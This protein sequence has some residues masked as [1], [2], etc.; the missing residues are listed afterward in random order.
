[1]PTK[2]DKISI[3]PNPANEAIYIK[4]LN[5]S[6]S[7]TAEIYN[8]YGNKI[9]SIKNYNSNQPINIAALSEGVYML[10]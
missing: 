5:E 1:M 4:D 9:L 7:L 8:S 2:I 3:Y 6:S 10:Y